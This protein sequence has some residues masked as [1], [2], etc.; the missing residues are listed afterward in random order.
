MLK[1]KIFFHDDVLFSFALKFS[2]PQR[3]KQNISV[4]I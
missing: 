2:N 1:I 3:D 4:A